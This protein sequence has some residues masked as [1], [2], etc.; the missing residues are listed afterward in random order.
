MEQ[1]I[2]DNTDNNIISPKLK[3]VLLTILKLVPTIFIC[4]MILIP[5]TKI[6]H[7]LLILFTG[8]M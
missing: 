6:L 4:L 2:P 5:V 1:N 7:W 3:D 8:A